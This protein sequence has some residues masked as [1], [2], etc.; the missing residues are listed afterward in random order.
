MPG[1]VIDGVEVVVPGLRIWNWND[2]S[3]CKL[4]TAD[5]KP[6]STL[7]VRQVIL[8]T[9]EGKW[10]MPTRAGAGPGGT[11]RNTADFWRRDPEHSGAHI[12][13]DNDGSVFCFADLKRHSAY[14]ATLSN[15]WS[16]GIEMR[17]EPTDGGVFAAVYDT[18]TKLVPVICRELMIPF[19]IAAD[20]YV[21]GKIIGRML[22]GGSDCVGIF[23][24]RDQSWKFPSQLDPQTR[25]RYPNGYSARGR[26]D[27]GDEIYKRLVAAGAEPLFFVT[28]QDLST[29]KRRQR[30][31]NARG[32]QLEVDGLAGPG[33]IRAMR[34]LGFASGRDIP[35]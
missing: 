7:W 32:A 20:A 28:Q 4:A 6:R 34:E 30:A 27:P 9:T 10:P 31:L 15:E 1:L 12:G 17:Q 29:W 5:Y 11:M 2:L 19:Q 3:W 25:M 26:G 13:I 14:H 24:H 35:T 18:C 16:V 33:T 21:S 8:H 23:G 22:H